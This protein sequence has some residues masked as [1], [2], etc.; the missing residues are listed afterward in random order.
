MIVVRFDFVVE[1]VEFMGGC[2]VL[3]SIRKFDEENL[4]VIVVLNDISY[5][6]FLVL[7]TL[8]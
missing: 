3:D 7:I 4:D 6:F 5:V 2:N 1:I 8:G